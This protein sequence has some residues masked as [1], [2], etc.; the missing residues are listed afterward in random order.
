MK[1][2]QE[3]KIFL[4]LTPMRTTF[5]MYRMLFVSFILL[6]VLRPIA[7]QQYIGSQNLHEY[8]PGTTINKDWLVEKITIQPALY[9]LGS[10]RIVF[11][12]GIISRTFSI[13][14]DGCSVG[15]DLLKGNVPFLRAVKP[16][17]VIVIDGGNI[18]V[19]GLLNQPVLNYF[20]NEWLP[21]MQKDPGAM[22]LTG[23]SIQDIK[24][25]FE[26]KKRSEWMSADLPWPP[27]GKELILTYAFRQDRQDDLHD[28]YGKELAGM[29]IN[30]VVEVH[31]ELYEG[32]PLMSKWIV[33]RNTGQ[34][35]VR[36]DHF[37]SEILAFVEPESSVGDLVNWATPNMTVETDYAFG[38]GMTQE[39]GL[40]KSYFW[41]TDST[42]QTVIN[43]NRVQ[44]TMLQV[45]PAL[46]PGLEI[47]P[48][49]IF[50]S[51]RVF[52]MLH[53]SNDRERKGLEVRRMYRTIA[54]WAFENPVLMHVR[55][56]DEASVKLAVDQCADAGFEMVILTFGS[57]FNLEDSS[58]ENLGK[59]K[60]LAEYAHSKGIALGGYSLLASRSISPEDDVVMP[61]GRQPTFGKSP[62]L[63]SEWGIRY[64]NNLYRFY[65]NTGLDVLEHDGS[66][67]GDVCMSADHPGHSGLLDSQWRQFQQI[68]VFTG[69]AVKRAF[70]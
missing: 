41:E 43:Y 48:G 59:M 2:S 7:A 33:V 55:N 4:P 52:E 39:S 20:R 47:G 64:F 6:V 62:C 10:D 25:R 17:A 22:H 28:I 37:T 15:L 27:P 5:L 60:N 32:L 56:A 14:P 23:Y 58:A 50:E 44:P 70:T 53:D 54:P 69:G 66:Y 42:Y 9:R 30:L 18:P 65:E 19:G 21:S 12:N 16:E 38:G 13:S 34:K 51:Y 36:L 3:R 67:P 61:E 45:K 26:W 35:P 8:A 68:R 31:Y 29:I 11:S 40:N 49:G 57:G 63:Q 46:G 24:K 1:G